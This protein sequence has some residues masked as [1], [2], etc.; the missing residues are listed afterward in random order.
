MAS[1]IV[2]SESSSPVGHH[3]RQWLLG[4]FRDA[5][6]LLGHLERALELTLRC[7][8]VHEN[9]QG[10]EQLRLVPDLFTQLECSRVGRRQLL[11]T[12]PGGCQ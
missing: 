1:E 6:H 5:E 4:L 2:E 7:M 12:G 3:R 11:R 9:E 8:V 10:L